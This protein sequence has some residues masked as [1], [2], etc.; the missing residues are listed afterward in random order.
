LRNEHI[1]YSLGVMERNTPFFVKASMSPEKEAMAIGALYRGDSKSL[2]HEDTPLRR[3]YYSND[4]ETFDKALQ[5]Y[6]KQKKVAPRSESH[7]K[8]W[9]K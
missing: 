8:F 7:K 9:N 3:A 6:Y 2:L 4:E 1:T 5:E